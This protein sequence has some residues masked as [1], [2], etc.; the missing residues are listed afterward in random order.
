MTVIVFPSKAV[1]DAALYEISC[2]PPIEGGVRVWCWF[3]PDDPAHNKVSYATS[4]D[5]RVA[6]SHEFG[7]VTLD[8]LRA[9]LSAWSGVLFLDS[10][11]DDW[12]YPNEL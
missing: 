3:D 8:W 4:T 1:A 9:Y 6:I 12:V 5:G 10:L 11:P 2:T 7:D